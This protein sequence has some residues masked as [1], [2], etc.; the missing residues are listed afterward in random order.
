MHNARKHTGTATGT[1][2]GTGT[3]TGT[4]TLCRRSSRHSEETSSS[5]PRASSD[6]TAAIPTACA[7]HLRH[8][9]ASSKSHVMESN[10][11]PTAPSRTTHVAHSPFCLHATDTLGVLEVIPVAQG[12]TS[13]CCCRRD[14]PLP[15][16]AGATGSLKHHLV[17]I[18]IPARAM[19]DRP[20]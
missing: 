2:S 6:T 18:Y 17:Y 10:R 7:H 15:V 12:D 14:R 4:D 9:I 19:Q 16:A 11:L 5:S 13:T 1:E 20:S 8:R 3:G